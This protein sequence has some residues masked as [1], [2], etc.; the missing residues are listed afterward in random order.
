[1]IY[2][3]QPRRVCPSEIHLE[4]DEHQVIRD[5]TAEGGCSGNLQGLAVLLRGMPAAEAVEK[6]RGIRC[7]FRST[8]CPDQIAAFLDQLLSQN[9]SG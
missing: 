1:M 8:S 6:L 5:L 9:L 3:F 2:T 7:G 4:V